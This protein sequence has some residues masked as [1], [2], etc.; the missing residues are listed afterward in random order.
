MLKLSNFKT[1]HQHNPLAVEAHTPHFGWQ[2][3]AGTAASQASYRILV[4]TSREKLESHTPDMWDS[5]SVKSDNSVSVEYAGKPLGS[6]SRYYVCALTEDSDGKAYASDI[7]TFETALYNAEDWKGKW[8]SV[9]VNFNGGTL[10][11]RKEI[12][13]DNKKIVRARA[14]ICGLGYHEFFVN[15]KKVGNSVLNPGVTEYSERV[16]YCAYDIDNAL[17]GGKNLIGAE[18]G[19]GWLGARKLLVQI[20]VEFEDG[21]VYEDHSGPGYGWWVAGSPTVDNSIYGGE[22]YDARIEEKYPRNWNTLEYEPTWANGWM[23][24]VYVAPP[25]GKL[26]AQQIEPIE[27]CDTYPEVS[28]TQKGKGIF[29]IDV[30][31][32]IAGW[33]RIRVRGERGASVTLK[34]GEQLTDDG[35]VNQ[36]NLRSARCSDTY[37]LSGEGEEEY[38]PRFTYHGFRYVQA[39]ITGKAELLSCVGEHV[40]TATRVVGQFDCSDPILNKL[41]RNA[42]VTELNNEHSILTDCPQRDE[43]FGWLNDLSARIYQ[44]MYNIDMARFIPKFIRDVTHTQVEDG[45]IADTAP[46]YTGGVPA[47]PVSVIYPLMADYMYRYYGDKQTAAAEY[48]GIKKWVDFLLSHSKDFIMDYYYYA[49]WVP[50]FSEV[51]A[52][53]LYV[54]TL[55]LYWHLREM[56]RVARIAGNKA[57]EKKYAGLAAASAKAINEKYFD[58]TTC[59]YCGGTQTENALAVSLGVAPEKYAAKVVENIYRDAVS[60][61]HHCTSGNIGYRHV[62]YVL[63]DY[64]YTDEVLNILRNPEYP[65]WGYMI[66]NGATSV[67]ERWEAEMQNLMHS[68]NH[69]MFGSYDAFFYRYLGG[70]AIEEDAVGGNKIRIE[71]QFPE[72]LTYVNASHETVHGKIVSQ[73]KR[74]KG[75]I[76]CHIEIPPQTDAVVTIGG[77]TQTLRGGSYDFEI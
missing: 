6:H 76:K 31:C 44:T 71:P 39:E 36:L 22:V 9:P 16:L 34:F 37:I 11:F 68:F 67:W 58:Q 32:N 73:W 48:D 42:V 60:R 17:H 53:E 72:S 74:E 19:Y 77:K 8:V 3:P 47:D 23:Y 46:Y 75:K 20:Y 35:Y 59:N 55:Y 14:Y 12:E 18:V 4:A 21:S 57:D 66:A 24:T 70:I 62:F 38:A 10:L 25:Q 27:V 30:G 61:N 15:G 29:I 7:C 41:H 49:D 63:A 5:G 43:R 2:Y 33:L 52:N 26:E 45:G 40:H 65:G 13:L 28:R 51:K 1:E 69:P 54:S 64:G 56:S 50:P